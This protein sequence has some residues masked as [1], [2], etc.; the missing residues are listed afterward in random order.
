VSAR[1]R[2]KTWLL[3]LLPAESGNVAVHGAAR[4]GHFDVVALL[5][6]DERV[7]PTD[8]NNTAIRRAS[9]NGH[10]DIVQLL[11]AY[12]ANIGSTKFDE[13]FRAA[14]TGFLGAISPEALEYL[15]DKEKIVV[16]AENHAEIIKKDGI[17]AFAE[18]IRS[19]HQKKRNYNNVSKISNAIEAKKIKVS[20]KK[21][22][23][24]EAAGWDILGAVIGNNANAQKANLTVVN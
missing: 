8:A 21:N 3:S 4:N 23:E 2:A 22:I 20:I 10:M 13:V 14:S 16:I 24:V 7:D 1:R 18:V 15:A 12:A 17:S 6:A 5:V 19:A 11:L 9:A